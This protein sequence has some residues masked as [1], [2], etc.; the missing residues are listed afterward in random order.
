VKNPTEWIEFLGNSEAVRGAFGDRVPELRELTLVQLVLDPAGDLALALN[1]GNLPE[2]APGRWKEKGCDRLQLRLRFAIGDV[3]IRRDEHP[4][5][6][7]VSILLEDKRLHVIS[8][9]QSFELTAGF[10]DARIEFFPYRA[11]D[12]EFPPVWFGQSS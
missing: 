4:R 9:D 6:Q 7:K 12:Y 1:Y 11:K 10:L 3:A 8:A 5:A 2:G